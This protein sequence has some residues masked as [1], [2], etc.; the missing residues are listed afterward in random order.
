MKNSENEE[1]RKRGGKGKRNGNR[2]GERKGGKKGGR[3]G[4]R[5]VEEM[6]KVD[7]QRKIV[8]GG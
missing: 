4:Q 8:K 1:Q 2:K 3:K 7:K 6:E 5:K